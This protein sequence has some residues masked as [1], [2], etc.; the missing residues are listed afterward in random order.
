MQWL[1]KVF[2]FNIFKKIAKADI[3]RT[4]NGWRCKK[5]IL[6]F[7]INGNLS[8]VLKNIKSHTLLESP[9]DPRWLRRVKFKYHLLN[10]I[11][12]Y[13]L[14]I[15]KW[16]IFFSMYLVQCVAFLLDTNRYANFP[17]FL[18]QWIVNEPSATYT[19]SRA[20]PWRWLTIRNPVRHV[21]QTELTV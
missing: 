17:L 20:K 7:W 13:F 5:G 14:Y 6:N 4:I 9:E 8:L 16:I 3:Q 19:N 1:F 12:I 11:N 15:S 2:N 18:V 21:V 10:R